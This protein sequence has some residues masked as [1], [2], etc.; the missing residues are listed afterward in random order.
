[1]AQLT[2]DDVVR[3]IADR[4]ARGALDLFLRE[5][6]LSGLDL[7][8]LDLHSARLRQAKLQLLQQF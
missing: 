2:R 4:Q 1:M 3:L 5:A 6:D 8:G 7:S